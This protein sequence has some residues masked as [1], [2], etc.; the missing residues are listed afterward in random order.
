MG[1][2]LHDGRT[3]G[4]QFVWDKRIM[5]SGEESFEKDTLTEYC[6][7][8]VW[9]WLQ[10]LKCAGYRKFLGVIDFC[11]KERRGVWMGRQNDAF[12][13]YLNRDEILADL[14][15][16]CLYEGEEVILP[17]Q[18]SEV[19]KNY[20]RTLMNYG[21]NG[22]RKHRERDAIKMFSNRK[23]M[24]LLAAE[25]QNNLHLAMP[26]RCME[27]DTEEYSRQ[28][29]KLYEENSGMLT[30]STEYLS[31]LRRTDRLIP[32]VTLVIYHGEE[33]WNAPKRLSDML[34]LQGIDEKLKSL[35]TDYPIH[36]FCL[37]DLQEEYFHTNL[38]ELIG[39]MKRQK[40]KEELRK[41]CKDNEERISRMDASAYDMICIMLNREDLLEKKTKYL[42]EESEEYDMCK[43]MEDW[44]EEC[45]N[46]GRASLLE[47]ISR[48]AE[49]G[50]A[51]FIVRLSEKEVMEAM[52]KKYEMEEILK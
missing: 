48:M 47:L 24:V 51:E 10:F 40:N 50:D 31:R 49:G 16:G 32:V 19:Q 1:C 52:T 29:K 35:I 3:A 11:W 14:Y 18:L 30:D 46:E 9:K 26:F 17:G 34:K 8:V 13:G 27:Y 15:N 45:R 36:V 7:E 42:K 38:R 28:L 20:S 5:R 25:A 33:E 23:M 21:R 37:K 4:I 12:V 43:A 6:G 44:A 41:Y 2:A 39:L 22:L